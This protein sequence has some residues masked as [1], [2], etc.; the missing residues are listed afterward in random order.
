M[1]EQV[2]NPCAAT[3]CTILALVPSPREKERQRPLS[4][5]S[6]PSE[7]TAISGRGHW[8]SLVQGQTSGPD[9]LLESMGTGPFLVRDGGEGRSKPHSHTHSQ[10]TASRDLCPSPSPLLEE[11]TTENC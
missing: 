9:S 7:T 5:L 1:F 10:V 11:N 2:W 4:R 8:R 3:I 6:C